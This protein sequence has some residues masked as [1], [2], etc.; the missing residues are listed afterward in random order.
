MLLPQQLAS[1]EMRERFRLEIQAIAGLEHPSILPVYQVGEHD[2]L[3]YFTMKYAS[4]GTLTERIGKLSGH[5]RAIA[6]LMATLADAVQFAHERGVLHR[7]LKPGNI[8]FDDEGRAYV[9]D[10]GLAKLVSAESDLTRSLE[11]LGT[12]HYL[13]PEI[14]AHSAKEAT[15]ASDIYSLGAIL[16]ELLA[17][18]PPSDA[19]GV[20][21]LLRQITD[22]EPA[23]PGQV[24]KKRNAERPHGSDA[25]RDLEVIALKC[26]AKEPAKRYGSARELAEDLRRWL[27]GRTILGRA[28]TRF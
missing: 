20:P 13:A 19:Q 5:W 21:A 22:T 18:R 14:A 9:S 25:P 17:G 3:P 16:Y 2:R 8:L 4:R 6:E 28:P 11:M 15:T 1:V 27:E 10:F 23:P 24:W 7:D 12:P 26:L